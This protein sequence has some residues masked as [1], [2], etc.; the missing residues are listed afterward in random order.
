MRKE[1]QKDEGGRLKGFTLIELLV[2]I[3]II[4][5]LAGL[6][7]STAGYVQKKGAASRAQGEIA[8]LAAA[9]DNYKADVGDYPTNSNS[10]TTSDSLYGV[11]SPSSGKVYFD[12]NKGMTSSAGIV[13]PFGATYGYTYPGATDRNGSNFFDLWSTAGSTN[14]NAWIKNW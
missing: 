11:L 13:D 10:G 12:F 7:L 6:V 8:A 14:P 4:A 1:S 3:A 2:V 9:L 5:I